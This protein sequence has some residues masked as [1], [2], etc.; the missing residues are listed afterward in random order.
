MYLYPVHVFSYIF[1]NISDY[2]CYLI[3]IPFFEGGG[4]GGGELN[5]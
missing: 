2:G 3:K 4:G 5:M 1:A